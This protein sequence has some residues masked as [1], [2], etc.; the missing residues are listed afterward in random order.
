MKRQLIGQLQRP[1]RRTEDVRLIADIVDSKLVETTTTIK[2]ADESVTS[3]ATLQDDDHFTGIELDTGK[4]YQLKMVLNLVGGAGGWRFAIDFSNVPASG[5][6]QYI[7][8]SDSATLQRD[9]T[10]ETSM[11]SGFV[12]N[13]GTSN[14]GCVVFDGVFKSN[15]TT[16]G[17]FK[18]VWAQSS[19]NAAAST[20]KEGSMIILTKLD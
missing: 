7:F 8:V 9:A 20:L 19:S 18:L 15:A 13:D 5:R 17:T 12:F 1:G 6:G 14:N 3:S 2:T 4:Y 16:G 11:E 10:S